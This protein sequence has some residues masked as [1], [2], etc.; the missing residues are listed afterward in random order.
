MNFD[1][2]TV[3]SDMLQVIKDTVK[4][5][6]KDIKETATSYAETKKER[7]DLLAS[8]RISNEIE[9]AFFVKRLKEEKK[10]LES[11]LLSLKIMSKAIA[12][13]AA[14]AAFEVLE[15]AINA[16]IHLP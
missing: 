3:I 1:I 5:H 2:N 14:N 10:I 11:E 15:K 4:T 8:L 12:Q 7:L 6:W 9:E 13:K 16:V